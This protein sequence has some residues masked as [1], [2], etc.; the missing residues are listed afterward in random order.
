[1]LKR[2]KVKFWEGGVAI[3]VKKRGGLN[4]R[5]YW[6]WKVWVETKEHRTTGSELQRV[7]SNLCVLLLGTRKV[8][9]QEGLA[10]SCERWDLC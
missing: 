5:S 1:M 3:A 7:A 4:S 8:R 9:R 10:G 6:K 2:W